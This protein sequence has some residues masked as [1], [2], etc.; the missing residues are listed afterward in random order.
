VV[1]DH[2][3]D[4]LGLLGSDDLTRRLRPV[5]IAAPVIADETGIGA[6]LAHDADIGIIGVCIFKPV[7]EPV[8]VRVSHD[9]DFDGGVL[10]RRGRR[11][12]RVIG[13]L[14]PLG[15][16]RPF[17]LPRRSRGLAIAPI[18]GAITPKSSAAEG[19]VKLLTWLLATTPWVSPVLCV[20]RKQKGKTDE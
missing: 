10:A 6:M 20:G 14:L 18:A 3:D 13:G 9:D 16:P 12:A 5:D 7:G 4:E 8:R 11:C 1:S 17:S 15:F 2:H 19:A